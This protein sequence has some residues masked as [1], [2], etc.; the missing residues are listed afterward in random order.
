[1]A[2]VS[3]RCW[4]R[5]SEA[6]GPRRGHSMT[7]VGSNVFVVGGSSAAELRADVWAFLGASRPVL[8]ETASHRI[9]GRVGHVAV[10]LPGRD[11]LLLLHGGG[12]VDEA[13]VWALQV[14]DAR[15]RWHRLLLAEPLPFLVHHS[16]TVLDRGNGPSP[17]LVPAVAPGPDALYLYDDHRLPAPREAPPL[18]VDRDDLIVLFG[19]VGVN[20]V[21]TNS[22][23]VVSCATLQWREL[24]LPGAPCARSCHSAVMLGA[25]MLVYGGRNEATV[26]DDLYELNLDTLQWRAV[27]TLGVG[28]GRRA[29]HTATMVG[30]HM[31][32]LGG[33]DGARD[34]TGREVGA[35]AMDAVFLDTRTMEWHVKRAAPDTADAPQPEA[36]DMHAAVLLNIV[37]RSSTLLVTGGTDAD[38]GYLDDAWCVDVGLVPRSLVALSLEALVR[39]LSQRACEASHGAWN[40]VAVSDEMAVVA[41][42]TAGEAPQ[43]HDLMAALRVL[44]LA[45]RSMA[46]LNLAEKL[47]AVEPDRRDPATVNTYN[48][49]RWRLL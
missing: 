17:L 15:P 21:H 12:Q 14:A 40:R 44:E 43:G 2:T 30:P 45:V 11:D 16:A 8:L 35:V 20:G 48:W 32:V 36:R 39:A 46:S 41:L 29:G 18:H 6:F 42:P 33:W 34:T 37:G 28:P 23:F 7:L 13:C 47:Q 31:V 4:V 38:F 24:A 49:L 10:A 26:F 19:G 3:Y 27:R 5:P 1:M 22:L 25:T 9:P